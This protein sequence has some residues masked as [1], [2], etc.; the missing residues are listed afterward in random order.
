MSATDESRGT[1]SLSGANCWAESRV[2]DAELVREA[3][4]P[5][6]VIPTGAAYEGPERVV[7]AASAHFGALGVRVEP[8]MV[9]RR[10]DAED[11][12]LAQLVRSASFL[13]LCGGSPL[14]LRSVLKDSLVLD[15][16]VG[17]WRDGATVA[18]QGAGTVVISDPMVDPRGGAFTVGFGLVRNLAAVPSAA[19][20]GGT[21]LRRTISL[22]PHECALVELA[23][24]G[25]IVR[26]S[27]GTWR[28]TG[29]VSIY[30]DQAPA[31][32][33][34]LAGKSVW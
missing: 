30:V 2:I 22:L 28:S 3:G 20:P 7:E 33:T 16:L 25:A 9:L 23:P 10:S 14:H 13:Y 29:G 11:P 19:T 15:A 5:V 32:L 1:L 21:G 17:A 18:G 27:D 4:T 8:A 31:D 24:D 26:S 34:A 12:E 6:L